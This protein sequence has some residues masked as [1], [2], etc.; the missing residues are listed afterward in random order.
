MGSLVLKPKGVGSE[1]QHKDGILLGW[2]V[3]S[4]GTGTLSHLSQGILSTIPTIG[5]WLWTW[6]LCKTMLVSH[7][8]L[9]AQAS[10]TERCTSKLHQWQSTSLHAG[11]SPGLFGFAFSFPEHLDHL[12]GCMQT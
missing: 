11:E 2:G 7:G 3:G 10:S 4:R 8:R 1:K 6:L 9:H 5:S 12:Q